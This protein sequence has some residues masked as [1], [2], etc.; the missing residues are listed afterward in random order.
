MNQIKGPKRL[1]P[2]YFS[3]CYWNFNSISAHDFS[4]ITQLKAYSSIYKHDFI[5]LS[6]TYLDSPTLFNDNS[7]QIG[8]YNVVPANHHQNDVKRGGLCIYYRQSLLVRVISIPYLREAVL[9]E[10][11]QNNNKI[12]VSVVYRT[13]SQTND[14]LTN[15]LLNFEK[16]LLDINFSYKGFQYEVFFLVVWWH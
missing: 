16:I 3:I 9:L 15:V 6:K 14:N 5:C 4:K 7:L 1:K 11:A 12:F 13:P 8:G 10:L 2:N